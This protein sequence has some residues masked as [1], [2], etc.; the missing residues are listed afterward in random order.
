LPNWVPM[1]RDT[2]PQRLPF[3]TQGTH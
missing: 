1:K 3:I 2:R